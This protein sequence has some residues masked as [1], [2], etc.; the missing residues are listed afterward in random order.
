[1]TLEKIREDWESG[2]EVK[3]VICEKEQL[4]QVLVVLDFKGEYALH[5]YFPIG[6]NWE[7]SVDVSNSSLERCLEEV[8]DQNAEY[9]P[10]G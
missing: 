3:L 7:V 8:T 1:M 2:G 4:G 6:K 10:K 5:R 9:Y